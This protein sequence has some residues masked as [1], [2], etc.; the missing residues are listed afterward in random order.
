MWF[1]TTF[2]HEKEITVNANLEKRNRKIELSPEAI[3]LKKMR[4]FRNYSLR[5]VGDLLGVSFTTVRHMEN[6]RAEIHG[7]YLK[8]FLEG[9]EFSAEDFNCFVKGKLKDEGLRLKCFKLIENIEPSKLEKVIAILS[10]I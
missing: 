6:G 3:A 10:V 1:L 4:V 9:L 8:N 7:E 2:M 5:N